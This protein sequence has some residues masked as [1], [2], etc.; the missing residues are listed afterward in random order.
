MKYS[1]L[2]KGFTFFRWHAYLNKNSIMTA[3]LQADSVSNLLH[4]VKPLDLALLTFCLMDKIAIQTSHL[5]ECNTLNIN[6]YM[7][8]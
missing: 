5:D 8:Y 7:K 6:L 1:F 4:P 3:L 2:Q